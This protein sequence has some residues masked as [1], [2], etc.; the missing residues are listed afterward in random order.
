[1]M[2]LAFVSFTVY[3]MYLCLWRQLKQELSTMPAVWQISHALGFCTGVRF[4][5]DKDRKEGK[6]KKNLSEELKRG[7]NQS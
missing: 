7:W 4:I 1:M 5:T 6:G 2:D 3:Y